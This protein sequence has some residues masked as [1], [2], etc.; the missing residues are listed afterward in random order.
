MIKARSTSTAPRSYRSGVPATGP[1]LLALTVLLLSL[2]ATYVTWRMANE[3]QLAYKKNEF[4][5]Q[6]REVVRR[7][8]RRMLNYEQV[9]RATMA[10]MLGSMEIERGDFRSFIAALSLKEKFP[11]IQ[12]VALVRIIPAPSLHQHELSQRTEIENYTVHPSG[13]REQYSAITH[14]EPFSGSNPRAL[15]FDMLSEPT[16]RLAMERARDSGQAAA[17]GKVRLVQEIGGP[18]QSGIVMYLPVY[19]RGAPTTTVLERRAAIIGWVGAPFRMSDL[20][21]GLDGERSNE[22]NISIFDG[23]EMTANARLFISTSAGEEALHEPHFR[24]TQSIFVAGRPWHVSLR[25]AARFEQRLASDKA[26]TIGAVGAVLSLL[27]TFLVWILASG[28]GRAI[29]IAHRMTQQLSDSEFRWK[30]ALE[31]A[32]DGVWDWN[33]ATGEMVFSRRWKEMLGYDEAE[34][35]DSLEVWQRLRHPDDGPAVDAILAQYLDSTD[36]L[37]EAEFRMRCKDGSWRWVL[38]RGMA[39]E[40]D[41]VG[42]PVRT[43]GTHTD[44]TR[45]KRDAQTLR[46]V[47]DNLI[48]EKHR[49]QVLLDHS[50]D[51][52]IA[53]APDGRVSDWNTKAEKMFGWQASEAIG[54][55]LATLIIPPEAQ[56]AHNAG[57]WRF[58]ASGHG[59]LV[60]NVVE[61][62]AIHRSGK[63][64]TVELAIAG[65]PHGKGYA[66]SAFLRDISERK[67]AQRQEA[68][69]AGALEE[70]RNA[71]QH[72]Q[73]LESVGKLTG[74]IAHDFNNVLHVIGAN[75][76]LMQM[77]STHDDSVRKRLISMQSA[78][79]RGAKL[80]SQLLSFAR[81]QPLQPVVV[82]LRETLRSMEDL[83]ERAVGERVKTI[84]EADPALWNTFVDPSQLANVI[85]NL[86]LNARDAI[87]G[88]GRLTIALDNVLLGGAGEPLVGDL[89]P[90]QYVRLRMTDTGEGMNNEV[91]ALAFEPF[92][93]TKPVGQGTG[94]GLSMAYGFVKQSGGH[95]QLASEPGKGTSVS[96]YLQRIDAVSRH[97]STP[98]LE[99]AERGSEFI[100]VVEDDPDVL[101]TAVSTLKEL[102]YNVL[103]AHDG[104]AALRIVQGGADIDLLFTDVVMPGPVSSTELAA[105]AQRALPGISILFTSGY[106]RNALSTDGRL[107][108]GIEL[109]SKPYKREQ[110]ATR[111]RQV[112]AAKRESTLQHARLREID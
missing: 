6:V 60:R 73:K 46:V 52:F 45:S 59:T 79:D 10:H 63:M 15:G 80:S 83:L 5:F 67:E 27:L 91:A 101:M 54:R 49:M 51:A 43:I 7:I 110:L 42:K 81:R 22:L 98:K 48:A 105:L 108:P 41:V 50:H 103:E 31:G 18:E 32:G 8:E 89:A 1:A 14:I 100:L 37:Y 106:T 90:G 38:A 70:A 13:P 95:I 104:E 84:V 44:V 40:R 12:G 92:Y 109:L 11:G 23:S 97:V 30:Y 34:I 16:R 35:V 19:R 111:I 47:N 53:L 78:V 69:R 68:E 61:V 88:S 85:L 87:R 96:I 99:E 93:T 56:A 3:Q 74:G 82:D 64:I 17:S 94:L 55:D 65:I 57:F 71:L 102:G 58:A 72:S 36:L 2:T 26:S 76:Q 75:I 86:A 9:A 112:L 33:R 20:M 66:V 39:V 24:T 62:T 29:A 4:E 25:S 28:R 107:D 21:A 77:Q